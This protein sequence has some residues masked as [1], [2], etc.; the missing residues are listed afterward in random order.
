MSREVSAIS[1]GWCSEYLQRA[2][3]NER[4]ATMSNET[5]D[6]K[7]NVEELARESGIYLSPERLSATEQRLKDEERRKAAQD[8][9][10]AEA[11][12]HQKPLDR[13][14]TRPVGRPRGSRTVSVI[15]ERQSA[16]QAEVGLEKPQ[17]EIYMA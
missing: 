14:A 1:A 3:G 6:H 7:K 8:A 2:R 10:R 4:T 9:E 17:K 11:R 16:D 12:Q 15:G 5:A 13:G